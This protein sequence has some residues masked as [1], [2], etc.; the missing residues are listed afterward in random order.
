MSLTTPDQAA[1]EEWQTQLAAKLS[2]DA[3]PRSK[4]YSATSLA[5]ALWKVDQQ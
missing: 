3:H 4:R 1:L 2:S 5:D